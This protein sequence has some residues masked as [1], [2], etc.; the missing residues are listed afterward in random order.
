MP[1]S[2]IM[3]RSHPMPII[4]SCRLR[5]DFRAQPNNPQRLYQ[6]RGASH[7]LYISLRPIQGQAD[8]I[9]IV[10][11]LS[12]GKFVRSQAKCSTSMVAKLAPI[13]TQLDAKNWAAADRETRRIFDPQSVDMRS[14]DLT[15]PTPEMIRAIDQAWL[16]ASEGR[17]GLT[18]QLRVWKIA[19]NRHPKDQDKAIDT[20]RDW[21]GWKLTQPRKEPDVISSDWR[22]ESELNY[23][24]R[25]PV[26]HLPWV[27]VSDAAVQDVAIPDDGQSCG[28]CTIDAMALRSS[29]FYLHIPGHFA[30]IEAALKSP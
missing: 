12:P 3:G 10:H 23:A 24:L 13:Q 18:V 22:N 30:R 11:Y 14:Q 20:L 5:G 26:G 15:R 27:G 28:S 4:P 19:Q 21:V 17:F 16:E 6:V 7:G 25:A 29:R 2:L 8:Q 1:R 9:Q